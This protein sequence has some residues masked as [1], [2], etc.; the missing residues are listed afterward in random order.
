MPR[1]Y[2]FTQNYY[3]V[4]QTFPKRNCIFKGPWTSNLIVCGYSSAEIDLCLQYIHVKINDVFRIATKAS[5]KYFHAPLK[6]AYP[7][8]SY[9][10]LLHSFFLSTTCRFWKEW[11][12]TKLVKTTFLFELV[13]NPEERGWEL[14]YVFWLVIDLQNVLQLRIISFRLSGTADELLLLLLLLLLLFKFNIFMSSQKLLFYRNYKT[15]CPFYRY[16]EYENDCF[17]KYG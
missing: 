5:G 12:L 3:E 14:W 8:P 7:Y 13:E 4:W 6:H 11:K 15:C 10:L 1:R 17:V 9:P 16:G 2:C